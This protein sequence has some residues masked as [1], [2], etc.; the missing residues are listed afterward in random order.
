MCRIETIMLKME[1]DHL[2]EYTN[3]CTKD[4]MYFSIHT[5]RMSKNGIM[6]FFL[7]FQIITIYIGLAVQQKDIL[8]NK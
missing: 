3:I 8:S 1:I 7:Y 4:N 5:I 2:N 6:I